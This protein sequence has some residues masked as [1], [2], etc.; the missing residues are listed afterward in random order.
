MAAVQIIIIAINPGHHIVFTTQFDS[1]ILADIGYRSAFDPDTHA[2][3]TAD[4][5]PGFID[6]QLRSAQTA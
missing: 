5:Q 6:V 1:S 2:V 4:Q 3:F